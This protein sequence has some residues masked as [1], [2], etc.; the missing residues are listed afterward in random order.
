M[1]RS[2]GIAIAATALLST[3]TAGAHAAAPDSVLELVQLCAEA[4]PFPSAV[5]AHARRERWWRLDDD[6]LSTIRASTD[7]AAQAERGWLNTQ[8]EV[9]LT[10]ATENDRL[11]ALSEPLQGEARLPVLA[12]TVYG[13]RTDVEHIRL[14]L[15]HVTMFGF[16]L[17]S[18]TS[19]LPIENSIGARQ[20]VVR[21]GR[22][23]VAYVFARFAGDTAIVEV[24]R[25]SDTPSSRRP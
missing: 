21:S 17:G 6:T 11:A 16:A 18:P 2:L 9:M 8:D 14:G 25:V 5:D 19:E 24:G 20:W 22:G 7:M 12:C 13:T 10:F 15:E 1:T 3:A 4:T 23:E